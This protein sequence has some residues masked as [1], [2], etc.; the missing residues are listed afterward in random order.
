MDKLPITL[1]KSAVHMYVCNEKFSFLSMIT[2][3]KYDS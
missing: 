3:D 2:R 1:L